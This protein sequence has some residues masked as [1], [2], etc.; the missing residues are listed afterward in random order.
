MALWTKW[1]H[2]GT[3][4][5]LAESEILVINADA[6][7]NAVPKH[8]LIHEVTLE[9]SQLYH[10]RVITA[11]PPLH[12]WPTD[13]SVP[14]A[15]P[16]SSPLSPSFLL[17]P[18]LLFSSQLPVSPLLSGLLQSE[19][20]HISCSCW[21]F[22]Q[23]GFRRWASSIHRELT[24]SPLCPQVVVLSEYPVVCW[25]PLFVWRSAKLWST[26]VLWYMLGV[27]TKSLRRRLST[28]GAHRW[29]VLVCH[30]KEKQLSLG[31]KQVSSS[32]L[33]DTRGKRFRVCGRMLEDKWR[34]RHHQ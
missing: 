20:Q 15:C 27:E 4:V 21:S 2:V 13:L 12:T 1:V 6:I 9:Y 14:E 23:D 3:A 25:N 7:L 26:C 16:R 29:C 32:D 28:F 10:H 33:C 24:C 18:C 30:G 17:C 19:L 11:R 8:R 31:R 5:T 22:V 34:A